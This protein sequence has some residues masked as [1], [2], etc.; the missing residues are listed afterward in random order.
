MQRPLS[1]FIVKPPLHRAVHKDA[2]QVVQITGMDDPCEPLWC[3]MEEQKKKEK[4]MNPMNSTSNLQVTFHQFDLGPAVQVFLQTID[5]AQQQAVPSETLEQFRDEAVEKL[6]FH[7]PILEELAFAGV[8][9]RTLGASFAVVLEEWAIKEALELLL[10]NSGTFID[11][12][13]PSL[14]HAFRGKLVREH[15]LLTAELVLKQ[16]AG[17]QT[18]AAAQPARQP[19]HWK[20]LASQMLHQ[21]HQH[22]LDWQNAAFQLVQQRHQH[23][24]DW[25]ETTYRLLQEQRQQWQMSIEVA[26]HWAGVAERSL[27]Q[28]QHGVDQNYQHIHTLHQQASALLAS[29]YE[30]QQ[31]VL[32]AAVQQATSQVLQ[33]RFA[34]K[35]IMVGV[36]LAGI[37]MLFFLAF[38][39]ATHLL[40]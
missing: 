36:I 2:V 10:R 18:R 14:Y 15:Q 25:Q 12:A 30:H 1:I 4:S 22:Q 17:K 19:D 13:S 23:Q 6:D 5:A 7:W 33:Q 38:F 3:G 28:A 21:Q 32:P 31:Q 29:T 20:D 16:E 39:I 27:E 24:L 8:D 11:P 34:N 37:G 40:P 35:L 9:D 26:R